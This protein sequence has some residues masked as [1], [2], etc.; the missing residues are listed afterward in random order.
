MAINFTPELQPY[1]ETGSFRF[2][3]QKVL[4]L[5]YDDS[6]SYYELLCKVVQYLNDVIA[7]ADGL[8][9]DVQ[10]LKDAFNQL[11]DYVNNYFDNLDIQEEINNKLDDMVEDGTLAGLINNTL[12]NELNTRIQLLEQPHLSDLCTGF[13]SFNHAFAVMKNRNVVN[14]SISLPTT[15]TTQA[16]DDNQYQFLSNT[17]TF[18]ID[19]PVDRFSFNGAG[20]N[21]ECWIINPNYTANTVSFRVAST[22]ALTEKAVTIRLNGNGR[23][24]E[25]LVNP[26]ITLSEKGDEVV[27]VA[28]TY[29]DAKQTGRD[30]DYGINFTYLGGQNIVN[31]NAGQARM[32]CDTLVC[33]TLMG[34]PYD[35][36]PYAITTPSYTYNFNDLI[37]NPTGAYSW[38]DNNYKNNTLYGGRLTNTSTMLWYW[39]GNGETFTNVD[40]LKNGDIAIFRRDNTTFDLVGHVGVIEIV[41]ENGKNVPYL[42]HVS[43]AAYTDGEIMSRVKLEDFYTMNQ[44][45]YYPEDTYF[46]RKN[47]DS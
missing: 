15:I 28:K 30:F 36:S 2:W 41:E 46:W 42:Y 45:R 19:M 37:V 33:M 4:P 7:N 1:K 39:W 38:A 17:M 5:V 9:N 13:I 16:Y 22:L 8:Y 47:W 20:D 14:M 21:S 43:V 23:L 34:I 29:W 35:E 12:F 25:P 3:C 44:G 31:N 40:S 10:A 11:Q 32:E 27:A 18:P 6:L 24:R 26:T